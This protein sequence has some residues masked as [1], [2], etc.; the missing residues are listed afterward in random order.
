MM[1]ALIATWAALLLSGCA[2]GWVRPGTSFEQTHDDSSYCDIESYG[3]Y[4]V[5]IV[6]VD[7]PSAHEPYDVDTNRILRD[8]EAKYCMRQ[9]GYTY[10]WIR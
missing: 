10:Q 8:N 2:M 7:S 1:R 5:N 9:K 3:K 6:H 4:P